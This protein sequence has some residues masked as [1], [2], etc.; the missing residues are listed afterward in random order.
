MRDAY[1]FE[2]AKCYEQAITERRAARARAHRRGPVR[3][4][5]RRAGPGR[6]GTCGTSWRTSRPSPAL[7]I[8]GG[9]GRS[10][11]ASWPILTGDEVDAAE[12]SAVRHAVDAA[13][14]LPL[15]LAPHGRTARRDPRAAH[16]VHRGE[17]RVRRS[18]PSRRRRMR[19]WSEILVGEISRQGKGDRCRRGCGG[20]PRL[21]RSGHGCSRRR[22]GHRDRGHGRRARRSRRTVPGSGSPADAGTEHW[23]GGRSGGSPAG[24]SAASP[25]GERS[26]TVAEGGELCGIHPHPRHDLLGDWPGEVRSSAPSV[27]SAISS[28]RSSAALGPA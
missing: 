4:R 11:D 20:P 1:A 14:A 17:H 8:V 24:R 6:P 21:R 13:G 5:G 16:A 2:L 7:R 23:V 27:V 18:S 15:V 25:A 3:L 26:E 12:L 9:T 19:A 22:R 28:T 10:T